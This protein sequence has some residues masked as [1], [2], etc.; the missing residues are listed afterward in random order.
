MSG[1][2]ILTIERSWYNRC[3]YIVGNNYETD[4]PMFQ[5]FGWH[6]RDLLEDSRFYLAC[7]AMPAEPRVYT[8]LDTHGWPRCGESEDT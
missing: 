5:R 6:V 4:D 1:W 7:G 8:Y 3:L 2:Q